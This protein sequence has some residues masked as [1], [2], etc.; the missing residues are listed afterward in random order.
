MRPT[1]VISGKIAVSCL[2]K[3]L[4]KRVLEEHSY[5]CRVQPDRCTGLH[6]LSVPLKLL[7]YILTFYTQWEVHPEP[8]VPQ[9][10][11][12]AD[13]LRD[14]VDIYF[15]EI[16]IFSFILHRP[17]FEKSIAGGLHLRNQEF[18][19]VVLAVCALASKNSSDKRVLLPGTEGELSAGYEWFR[20]IRRPFSG[21]VVKTTSLYELQLCCV[22]YL[23]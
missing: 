4:W 23:S 10:F 5:L 21:P 14:L 19:A 12:P 18:G 16:N 11:P 13:L 9:M 7:L 8:F 6:S 22:C 20:Q 3:L 15:T 17:T 2:L 1:T